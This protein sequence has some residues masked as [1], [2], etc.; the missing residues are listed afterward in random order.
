MHPEFVL[1]HNM[2]KRDGLLGMTIRT[3][4]CVCVCVRMILGFELGKAT[5]RI[6]I[7]FTIQINECCSSSSINRYSLNPSGTLTAC[8]RY[9]HT[10]PMES[11]HSCTLRNQWHDEHECREKS[12]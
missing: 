8:R 3:G 10:P 2:K 7:A 9:A 4:V 6:L 11:G 12:L 1:Q 5:G